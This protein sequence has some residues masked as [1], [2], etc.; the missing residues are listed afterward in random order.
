MSLSPV[1]H[2]NRL[3]RNQLQERTFFWNE[4]KSVILKTKKGDYFWW[5]FV[6]GG[7]Y[8]I[9]LSCLV[10]DVGY[11]DWSTFMGWGHLYLLKIKNKSNT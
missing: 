8:M 9:S 11:H 6:P 4:G 2:A 3:A 1:Y 7:I 10:I 5:Q